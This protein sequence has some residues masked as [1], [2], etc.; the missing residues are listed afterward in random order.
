MKTQKVIL[1]LG[2]AILIGLALYRVYNSSVVEGMT[3][4]EKEK[5]EKEMQ[6]SNEKIQANID[7]LKKGP[8]GKML[9]NMDNET[10]G[11]E[12]FKDNFIILLDYT[13]EA[14]KNMLLS[15]AADEI[16]KKNSINLDSKA[17]KDIID[18]IIRLNNLKKFLTEHKDIQV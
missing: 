5:A 9:L 15:G 17:Q 4:K 8:M 6:K 3:D 18:G 1:Y 16:R 7:E 11:W 10:P 14:R 13:I 2:C 12:E